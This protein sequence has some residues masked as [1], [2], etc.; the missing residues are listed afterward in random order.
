MTLGMSTL[1]KMHVYIAYRE[2]KA[3]IT[4]SSAAPTAAPMQ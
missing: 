2:R 4:E 3:Y 1:G